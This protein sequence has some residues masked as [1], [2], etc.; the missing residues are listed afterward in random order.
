[1]YRKGRLSVLFQQC[2]IRA[3]KPIIGAI[4]MSNKPNIPDY[5]P[6]ESESNYLNMR[7]ERELAR[8]LLDKGNKIEAKQHL[9]NAMTSLKQI[10]GMGAQLNGLYRSLHELEERVDSNDE[11]QTKIEKANR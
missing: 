9:E 8:Q 10:S 4:N 3:F 6:A 2:K 11:D 5:I 1:M 7:K